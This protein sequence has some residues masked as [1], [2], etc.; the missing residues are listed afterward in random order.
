[1]KK[2]LIPALLCLAVCQLA[3]AETILRKVGDYSLDSKT[4]KKPWKNVYSK[5]FYFPGKIFDA[6]RGKQLEFRAD[7]RCLAGSSPLRSALRIKA[8]WTLGLMIPS[9]SGTEKRCAI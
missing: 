9:K 7:V 5:S 8:I 1:M 3:G 4:H 6:H 2:L